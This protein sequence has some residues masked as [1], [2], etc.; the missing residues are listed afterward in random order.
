M[1]L[2]GGEVV[3]ISIGNPAAG[4]DWIYTVPAEY[5][6]TLLHVFFRLVTDANVAV[7][8]PMWVMWGIDG[9]DRVRNRFTTNIT[10]GLTRNFSYALGNARAD[11]LVLVTYSDALP[12]CRW[13][14]GEK[15]GPATTGLQATDQFS[16]IHQLVVRWRV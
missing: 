6:M 11:S 14:P 10:A 2:D 9:F 1:P 16:I 3:D 8:Y 4:T 13:G 5:E 12:N 7:R 15:W